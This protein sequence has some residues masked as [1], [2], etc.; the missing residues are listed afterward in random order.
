MKRILSTI[1]VLATLVGCCAILPFGAFA[2]TNGDV[3]TFI[4][5]GDPTIVTNEI[6]KQ[7][8]T[9]AQEKMDNDPNMAR[10]VCVGT[11]ELWANV[12]TGEVYIKDIATGQIMISNPYD[13]Q[14]NTDTKKA[15]LMS[16]IVVNYT[17]A[18]AATNA[19]EKMYSFTAAAARGQ[20][21]MT[22]VENGIR[23]DYIMGDTTKRY[24][25]PYGIDAVDYI[26]QVMVPL[27]E[28]TW[29]LMYN[30]AKENGLP[31]EDLEQYFDFEAYCAARPK[32]ST[33]YKYGQEYVFGN[34]DAF[35]EWASD[36]VA[37][38]TQFF[39][40]H[41]K[42]EQKTLTSTEDFSRLL[43]DFY[44]LNQ[45]FIELSA[46]NGR[47]G[48]ATPD[49][50]GTPD[51]TKLKNYPYLGKNK[52]DYVTESGEVIEY[53]TNTIF[54]LDT[55]LTPRQLRMY[56]NMFRSYASDFTLDDA[57]AAE[58]K[59][60]IMPKTVVN[61]VFY[62]SLV[63]TLTKDGVDVEMPATS[64]VY[65]ETLYTVNS[66]S[67][68]PY[69]NTGKVVD[70]GYVFYPDGSGAI[71]DFDD[72]ET[73]YAT[74]IG[75]V[76]GADY[77][78][79]SITGQHQETISM[80]VY[81]SV[82]EENSYFLQIPEVYEDIDSIVPCT[83]QIFEKQSYTIT[84]TKVGNDIYAVYPYGLSSQPVVDYENADGKTVPLETASELLA[85]GKTPNPNHYK[86]AT[87][88]VEGAENFSCGEASTNGFVAIMTEGE[89]LATLHVSLTPAAQ[90]PY[91]S[92]Y[93]SYAL[94]AQDSYNLMD[95]MSS[96]ST[97]ATFTVLAD[98]KYLGSY[99]TKYIML[100]DDGLAAK[101][102][103]TSYYPATY[104]GMAQAY[105]QYLVDEGVLSALTNLQSQLPLYV[106]SFGVIQTKKKV[107]SIPITVDTALTTF[108]N[109]EDMYNELS[110]WGIK[111]VK[112]RLSG[113]ANGGMT[114]TYPVKLKWERVAGG[115]S[116]Y[117]D[118]LAYANE[119]GNGIEIF[120]NF[121]FAYVAKLGRFDGINI[122]DIGSRSVD[123][124]YASRKAYSSVYQM[125]TSE[126]LFAV[127]ANKLEDLFA[128]FNKKNQKYGNTAISLDYV[129][130]DLSTD[131][132]EDNLLTRDDSLDYTKEFLRSVR[133]SGYSS[134]MSVG[135]N[136]YAFGY[137]DYLLEAPIDSSHYRAVSSTVP[138]WGMVMHGYMNYSGKA[139]NE[140]A[141][142]AEAIL[143]A[144]ESGAA[145]YFTLSYDNTRLLKDNVLLS[146]Y[147]SVNY[148]ISKETVKTYYNLLNEAIGDLQ[149]HKISNHQRIYAERAGVDVDVLEQ[150]R[151]L[152][153]EF[154][155]Q[156][157]AKTEAVLEEQRNLI[158][159]LQKIKD[160][161]SADVYG[162]DQVLASLNI[163]KTYSHCKTIAAIID[164]NADNLANAKTI[165]DA[166][167]DGTLDLSYG[168]VI[169]A[170]FNVD[171]ILAD[172]KYALYTDQLSATFEAE[173]RDYMTSMSPENAAWVADVNGVAYESEYKYYTY[174]H[175]LDTDYVY[176]QSTVD[177]G[178]VVLV[179]Y[180]KTTVVDGVET[181]S[182][183]KFLLNFNIFNV[184][185]RL[186][187]GEVVTLEKY[188]YYKIEN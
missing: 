159:A 20:I 128:K 72:F 133:E 89:A 180:S 25:M 102:G 44:G 109:I 55:T 155:A 146:R 110:S 93:A 65:D 16:Q 84:Y 185:V 165:Y 130:S 40:N 188:S 179:T 13:L 118:L 94:R 119:Q 77:A 117:R 7:A 3:I 153:Q 63:Y 31:D 81:G 78:Y 103:V 43:D 21:S 50:W 56:E 120:P 129:A 141:N 127:S 47:K 137:V 27:Q 62:V 175:A 132:S 181:T 19:S 140:Q 173:I 136:A 5:V 53:M 152:E 178:T 161:N 111:N 151:T 61:P 41:S 174:S 18:T 145:L 170:S 22:P 45:A 131:F 52:A 108:D 42:E 67:V 126:G 34:C 68:L 166:I 39:K 122:K 154:M 28:Q 163:V 135:G 51:E 101:A 9:S 23:L 79:Y 150:N 149:D 49:E 57:Y 32:Y 15:E 148:E 144:I 37:I 116:G 4:P 156:L 88:V 58:E 107:L 138:F 97:S 100:A 73:S 158:K 8:Y 24:V 38:Y 99:T 74:L 164:A 143:R 11:K 82:K 169:G 104:V 76:Y 147:Y 96:I 95:T 115:K 160:E 182:T 17:S 92:V 35:D 167:F 139:F 48:N 114:S 70:G 86:N 184:N 71:I 172:A 14:G 162:D 54:V 90:D 124:R 80:P 10:Y 87:M 6:L 26:D 177:N 64:I 123:N 142:K 59:T 121:N 12:L 187:N 134:V 29:E 69:F 91:S 186:E 83:K 85:D 125:F 171:Q 176:T 30:T 66:I 46:Y 113:F 75:Q 157:Q 112:F 105:Q 98:N 33:L 36:A 168:Q 60:G 106:E 2:R 183:T 1:L